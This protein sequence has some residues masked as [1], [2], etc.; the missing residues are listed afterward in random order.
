MHSNEIEKEI[1][2]DLES[3]IVVKDYQANVNGGVDHQWKRG[4]SH[5][6]NP[7]H[8]FSCIGG[9]RCLQPYTRSFQ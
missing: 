7:K 9:N 6:T 5:M 4:R 3:I 8:D 2:Q 1:G